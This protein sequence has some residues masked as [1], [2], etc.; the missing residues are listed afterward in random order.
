ME[1]QPLAINIT[2]G[3]IINYNYTFGGYLYGTQIR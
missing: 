3:Y 1:A 2:I